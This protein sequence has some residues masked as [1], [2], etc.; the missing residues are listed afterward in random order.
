MLCN[1]Q[2]SP[3]IPRVVLH[4][5]SSVCLLPLCVRL[6][7][8][9]LQET[10]VSGSEHGSDIETQYDTHVRG[11]GAATALYN[12]DQQSGSEKKRFLF[13]SLGCLA[14]KVLGCFLLDWCATWLVRMRLGGLEA[15]KFGQQPW[16]L[17]ASKPDT[18]VPKTSLTDS[19]IFRGVAP[20]LHCTIEPCI[21][22]ARLSFF[23]KFQNKNG[24]EIGPLCGPVFLG[25][26]AVTALFRVA[27]VYV[28]E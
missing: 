22:R 13:F 12:C 25:K 20:A 1:R 10:D 2:T 7:G 16:S 9:S 19:T 14:A 28:Y 27:V 8:T 23:C 26:G 17:E 4:I 3:D 21:E 6:R 24:P 15:W 11:K 5:Y 18:I